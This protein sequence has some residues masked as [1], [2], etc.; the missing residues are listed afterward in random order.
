MKALIIED[1]QLA[2]A[3]LA[4]LLGQNFPD[5]E[6]VGMLPSVTAAVEWLRSPVNVA[7]IIFMDVELSD[8]SCFEIFRQVEVRPKVVMTTAYD[9]YAVKAFEVNSV[10]YLL[11]PIEVAALKRAVERVMRSNNVFDVERLAAALKGQDCR[12][13]LIVR[14]ND[15]IIPV[16]V[17]SVA[18]FHSSEKNTVLVLKDG[19]NYIY[20]GTL[21]DVYERLDHKDFFRISR[22]CILALNS[23]RSIT[24][25]FGGRLLVDAVPAAS[26]EMTVSRSRVDDFLR[27]IER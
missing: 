18:Y 16:D 10:D 17:S 7:D 2:C 25:Q 8:G 21:D 26:F 3:S 24:K 22:N 13:R 1:E 5:M 12:Q 14:L 20:D 6:I 23:I 4:R 9:N 19:M 11:K 15:K 27:W